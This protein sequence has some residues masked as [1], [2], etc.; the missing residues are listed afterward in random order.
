ML[1][2]YQMRNEEGP[3]PAALYALPSVTMSVQNQGASQIYNEHRAVIGNHDLHSICTV[4]MAT[5]A[6]ATPLFKPDSLPIMTLDLDP[7]HTLLNG[8]TWLEI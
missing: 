5:L 8:Q 7:L 6:W 1:V 3:Q 4:K 2:G